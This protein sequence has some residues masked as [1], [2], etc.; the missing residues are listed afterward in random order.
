[1]IINVSTSY[2]RNVRNLILKPEKS[3][4]VI[5]Y[6][7][8]LKIINN[9]NKFKKCNNDVTILREGQLK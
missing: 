5:V 8:I 2:Q 3:N 1:M 7:C 9:K 6:V 4:G